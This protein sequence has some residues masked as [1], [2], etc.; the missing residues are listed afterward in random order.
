MPQGNKKDIVNDIG[1]TSLNPTQRNGDINNP[2]NVRTESETPKSG[3]ARIGYDDVRNEGG[4][5]ID[6]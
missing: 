5:C 2:S 3:G 1:T 4:F 6:I